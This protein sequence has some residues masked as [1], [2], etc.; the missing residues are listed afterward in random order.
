MQPAASHKSNPIESRLEGMREHPTLGMPIRFYFRQREKLLYLGVGAWNTL[1]GYAVWALLQYTLGDYLSYA[2]VLV[3]AWPIVVLNAYIGYR[4][5]VFRSE[6]PVLTE[7]PR[8]SLVYL[9]T[10]LANLIILP[11]ALQVLPFNIYVIEALFS[12]AVVVSGYLGHKYFS[13][14]G[15][16]L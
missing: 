15:P 9:A 2:V 8:F 11:V 3:L 5:I 12:V 7:L 6:G 4:R 10:L 16:L 14:R 1:F 13:F